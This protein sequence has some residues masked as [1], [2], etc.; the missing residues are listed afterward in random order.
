[1]G[2]GPRAHAL[3][4]LSGLARKFVGGLIM[5]PSAWPVGGLLLVL[6]DPVE[7]VVEVS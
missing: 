7:Q 2:R 5:R 6:V 1:M 3:A 4:A